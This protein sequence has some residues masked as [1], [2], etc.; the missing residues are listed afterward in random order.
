MNI[1]S[2]TA[3]LPVCLRPYQR[4][5]VDLIIDELTRTSRAHIS[6]PTGSGKSRVL[7]GIASHYLDRITNPGPG[8]VLVISPRVTITGQ[9]ARDL[10]ATGHTVATLPSATDHSPTSQV[11]VGTAASLLRWCRRTANRPALILV[12]EAH[13]ATAAGCRKLL[14]TYPDAH[15]AGVTATPYRHDGTRLDDVLGRCAMIRDPDSPDMV[16]VLAPVVWE[17]V[18]LPVDLGQVP[19]SRSKDGR[20]YVTSRLGAVLTT[21][22]AI[23]ATV[24]G[25]SEKICGRP[26][27]VF[28]ATIEHGRALAAA[29]LAAGHRVGQVY[30][31]TP[32]DERARLVAALTLG[33]THPEGLG[34]LVSVGALTEG[35]DCQPVAALVIAR[36]TRSELMYT[37]MVGRGLRSCP[38]K[39][40]CLVFDITGTDS[41]TEPTATGQVFAPTVLRSPGRPVATGDDDLDRDETDESESEWWSPSRRQVRQ[42]IGTNLRAPS[43]SWSPGPDGIFTVPLVDGQV[44]I[45]FPDEESGLWSALLI[46]SRSGVITKLADP[47]PVRHA[48]D[49]FAGMGDRHLTRA[50]GLWR[51]HPPTDSQLA[52]LN[53][54]DPTIAD[55]A[56]FDGWSKG[57][58]CD[59][60]GAIITSRKVTK[61]YWA[62]SRGD[63][64]SPEIIA[65]SKSAMKYTFHTNSDLGTPGQM[66]ETMRETMREMSS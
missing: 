54:L 49:Q 53:Q 44:G 12:D 42:M 8:T 34:I 52:K 30:G 59:V 64:V 43:W 28:A 7:V 63:T 1:S 26:T 56:T 45:L 60:I 11:I 41:P 57:H 18:A 62:V 46:G 9:L 6:L 4:T 10:T 2:A 33:P 65:Q 58:V 24:A 15:R 51:S 14:N 40:D 35:F 61:I 32:A 22:D 48:V 23:A 13:H 55:Q 25:T 50:D 27:V 16:G 5:A 36:P 21:P 37:Q 66:R 47:L 29:Y 3:A 19:T 38:G 17:P 31:T 20:D 39:I